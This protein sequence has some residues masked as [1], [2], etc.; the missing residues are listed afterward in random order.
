MTWPNE[1]DYPGTLSNIN[2]QW[3]CEQLKTRVPLYAHIG[4]WLLMLLM[5]CTAIA[6]AHFTVCVANYVQRGSDLSVDSNKQLCPPEA[7]S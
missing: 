7:E 4:L 3:L 5:V 2:Q 6:V 1:T